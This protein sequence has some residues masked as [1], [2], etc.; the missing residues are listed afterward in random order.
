M[1]LNFLWSVEFNKELISK[2]KTR[3]LTS[4]KL[5][6]NWAKQIREENLIMEIDHK[7]VF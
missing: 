5:F 4:L 2:S 1:I 6:N 7:K 3:I